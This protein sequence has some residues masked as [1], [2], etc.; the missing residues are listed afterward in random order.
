MQL[1]N[2][3][4]V[5]MRVNGIWFIGIG[6]LMLSADAIGYVFR[7]KAFFG[8]EKLLA[9]QPQQELCFLIPTL[10]GKALEILS[11]ET[12]AFVGHHSNDY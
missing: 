3:A 1:V 7:H 8:V 4:S 2:V 12:I 10:V 9:S 11:Q 6:C 5:H